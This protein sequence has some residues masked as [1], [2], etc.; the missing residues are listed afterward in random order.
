MAKE[1]VAMILAGGRGSRVRFA[2]LV[3]ASVSG[4]ALDVYKR[5]VLAAPAHRHGVVGNVFQLIAVLQI[6]V[7]GHD[8]AGVH[9]VLDL[10]LIHI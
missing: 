3:S 4:F 10:S 1:I 7:Q 5:Q 2:G 8:D 9:A 6:A